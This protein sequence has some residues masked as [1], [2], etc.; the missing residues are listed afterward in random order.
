[1][2]KIIITSCKLIPTKGVHGPVLSPYMESKK[3]ICKM[4]AK[5]IEIE[6]VLDNGEH[7]KL[8]IPTVL[9]DENDHVQ[10]KTPV[11]KKENKVDIVSS[12]PEL[13]IQ[14]NEGN[15]SRKNKKDKKKNKNQKPAFEIDTFESK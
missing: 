11:I 13:A 1:M 5:G 12:K 6:E 4:L 15:D 7:R 3:E 9:N 14:Y 8:D 10:E 2:K